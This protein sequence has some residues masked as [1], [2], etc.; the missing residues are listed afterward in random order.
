MSDD[1]KNSKPFTM[2]FAIPLPEEPRV[3]DQTFLRSLC[4]FGAFLRWRI[5]RSIYETGLH[6][7]DNEALRMAL[8]LGIWEQLGA[9]TEDL[10]MF[11]CAAPRWVSSNRRTQ[12]ADLYSQ[13]QVKAYGETSPRGVLTSLTC[14]TDTDFVASFGLPSDNKAW[15]QQDAL[16]SVRTMRSKLI[17]LLS[18][19]DIVRAVLNKL[20]HGPQMIVSAFPEPTPGHRTGLRVAKLLFSGARLAMSGP[21]D[22]KT[23]MYVEDSGESI[24]MAVNQIEFISRDLWY[25]ASWVYYHS[26]G[27]FAHIDDGDSRFQ[28]PQEWWFSKNP[29]A[30]VW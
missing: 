22:E 1:D 20:K 8:S 24:P 17:K 19:G 28:P 26:F 30:G 25:L 13:I 9:Q 4:T 14:K 23:H 6:K 15:P 11:L 3:D 5:A 7:Q 12:L 10:L 21:E 29:S 16:D 27:A 18:E 2:G